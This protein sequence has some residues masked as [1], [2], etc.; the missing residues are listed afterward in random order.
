VHQELALRGLPEELKW[1]PIIESSYVPYAQSWAE[2]VGLWQFILDTGKRYGLKRTPWVDDRLDPYKATP[3]AAAYLSDLHDM[4]GDWLLALAAYNCGEARVL[5]AVNRYG[6]DF[7]KLKLPGE[8]MDY[9][10]R[11]L[12]AVIMLDHPEQYGLKLPSPMPSYLFEETRIEKSIALADAARV[13]D[14]PADLMK[15]LNGGVRAGITPPEGYDIRVPLGMGSTLMTRL[16]DIPEAKMASLPEARVYRVRRGDT[17]SQIANRFNTSVNSIKQM[18]KLRGNIIHIG[19]TLKVPGRTYAIETVASAVSTAPEPVETSVEKSEP[20]SYRVR[21]GDTLFSIAR[22]HGTTVEHIKALNGLRGNSLQAGQT[23]TLSGTRIAE[24][25]SA[26]LNI[27]T[28]ATVT[29]TTTYKVRRGDTLGSIARAHGVTVD[30]LKNANPKVKPSRLMVNQRII[31][32]GVISTDAGRPETT[33]ASFHTVKQG[34]SLWT[35]ARMY[36]LSVAQMMKLNS[37]RRASVIQPG[38]RLKVATT[39]GQEQERPSSS[40][41][42]AATATR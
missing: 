13:L 24:S 26:D 31:I 3:A 15:T 5:R 36:G 14:V 35:I 1:L 10:P 25:S 40:F 8:T 19:Q 27:R 16:N 33:L 37:L 30:A 7:W 23:L 34:E 6:N 20:S 9:V 32:P 11:F 41:T 22:R 4:F 28:E 18:N 12:A 29:S 38:Q 17:L 2:A 39:L 21:K 42:R